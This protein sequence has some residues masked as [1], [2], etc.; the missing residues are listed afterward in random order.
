MIEEFKLL[1]LGLA[2]QVL[3]QSTSLPPPG[4]HMVPMPRVRRTLSARHGH[5][6]FRPKSR[7][8]F[9][10]GAQEGGQETCKQKKGWEM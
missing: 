6:I 3:I 2:S 10:T 5:Q 4:F 1:T 9:G 8:D 7:T